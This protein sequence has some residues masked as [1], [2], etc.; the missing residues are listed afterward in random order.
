MGYISFGWKEPDPLA[1]ELAGPSSGFHFVAFH[2]RPVYVTLWRPDRAGLLIH[3]DMQDV[4]K[5]RSWR[6]TI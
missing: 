3:S 2:G 6:P 4:A 1:G 5:R